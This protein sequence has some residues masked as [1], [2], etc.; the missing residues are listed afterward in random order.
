MV[1]LQEGRRDHFEQSIE[2]SIRLRLQKLKADSCYCC[3][4][5][6]ISSIPCNFQPRRCGY[7]FEGGHCCDGCVRQ[8]CWEELDLVAFYCRHGANASLRSAYG[9]LPWITVVGDRFPWWDNDAPPNVIND[10]GRQ[11]VVYDDI[12]QHGSACLYRGSMFHESFLV[13]L[14]H[15]S[16]VMSAVVRNDS[17]AA[18]SSC[19]PSASTF[20]DTT[21]SPKNDALPSTLLRYS[22][23]LRRLSAAHGFGFAASLPVAILRRHLSSTRTSALSPYPA[24]RLCS[25]CLKRQT[26]PESH[27]ATAEREIDQTDLTLRATLDC[28]C[29]LA[30]GILLVAACSRLGGADGAQALINFYFSMIKRGI[31]WLGRFPIGFKLNERLTERMGELMLAVLTLNEAMLIGVVR[32]VVGWR[33]WYLSAV[34]IPVTSCA[35]GASGIVAALVD[36]AH[37]STAQLFALS[38]WYRRLY[39]LELYLLSSLW[40]LLRGK[41]KNVLRNRSD[42]MEYDST[43]LLLGTIL[44]T[45]VTALLTTVLVYHLFFAVSSFAVD[46]SLIPFYLLHFALLRLPLGQLAINRHSS[47]FIE[48][49]KLVT[50]EDDPKSKVDVTALRAVKTSSMFMLT[51]FISPAL[52][53]I[54]SRISSGVAGWFSGATSPSSPFPIGALVE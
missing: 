31:E 47:Y 11:L 51:G 54:V 17:G 45:I 12:D 18:L 36:V 30:I 39:R 26:L 9:H 44:F 2:N 38:Y 23:L 40:L 41:K 32:W 33:L 22:M 29:G 37:L 16:Q 35:V 52:T 50:L 20:S 42:T 10:Q 6:E 5:P 43:Q 13:R 28:A 46:I 21:A 19:S 14:C 1:T 3:E 53:T 4:C 15:S 48:E 25:V 34:L 24:D 27:Y 49:L 7:Q 8:F